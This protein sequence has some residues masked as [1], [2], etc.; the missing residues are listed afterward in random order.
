MHTPLRH[1]VKTENDSDSRV[2]VHFFH[3]FIT[4]WRWRGVRCMQEWRVDGDEG[5]RACVR[6]GEVTVS[7]FALG[8]LT[9]A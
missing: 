5:G 7:E 3:Y 6:V 4:W 9:R 1:A 2:L 8:V